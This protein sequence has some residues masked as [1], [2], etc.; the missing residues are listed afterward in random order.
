M[1]LEFITQQ[2]SSS[3]NTDCTHNTYLQTTVLNTDTT[4]QLRVCTAPA[5]CYLVDRARER[6]TH[7]GIVASKVAVQVTLNS[8]QENI[9]W[10][11]QR[12]CNNCCMTATACP[13]RMS[14]KGAAT[15]D[16]VEDFIVIRTLYSVCIQ[17]HFQASLL[18][19]HATCN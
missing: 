1:Q 16:T 19:C 8:L 4:E 9:A 5:P 13:G 3:S 2:L 7:S 11:Q 12:T 6:L 14:C 10:Q 15:R 18:H 17:C